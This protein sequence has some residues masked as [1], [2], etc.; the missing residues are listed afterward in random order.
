[1]ADLAERGEYDVLVGID[2]DCL[3]CSD[4]DA[5]L[6]ICLESGGFLGGKDGD[7]AEYDSTYAVY[8]IDAPARNERYMSTSL[9]FCAVNE[10]EQHNSATV[11][12]MLHGSG[13]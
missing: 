3:L 1:M 11:G 10:V 9:Y 6:R 8:G 5:E 2:S 12:G 4:V 7:G 13:V